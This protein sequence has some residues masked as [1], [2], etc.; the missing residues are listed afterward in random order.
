MVVVAGVGGG[1]DD[2]DDDGEVDLLA[3]HRDIGKGI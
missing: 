1:G 2:G 3:S